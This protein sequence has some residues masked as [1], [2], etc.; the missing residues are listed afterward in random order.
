MIY[1]QWDVDA[2]YYNAQS[3][4]PYPVVCSFGQQVSGIGWNWVPT[5]SD[6]PPA[7]QTNGESLLT[8]VSYYQTIVTDDVIPVELLSFTFQVNDNDVTLNWVTATETNNFGFE[9]QRMTSG[10][11]STIGFING[12]G[13]S[14]ETHRYSYVDKDLQ[15]GV[16]TYRLKQIDLDG[17]EYYYDQLNVEVSNPV[18]F[19]LEQNY[20]N[21]FNP[22]TKIS[23]SLAVDSRVN[24]TVYNLLGETVATLVNSEVSAGNHDVNFQAEN[25]NSGI[26]F[27]RLD[28]DGKDGSQFSQVRKMML[29]K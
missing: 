14:T 24:L 29:T 18:Q 20:P 26:Y 13:T 15:P 1:T 27:Y 28:V 21:P 11:F 2:N 3:V 5:Y 16:Y 19:G 9:V 12:Y 25:L 17:S 23:Y 4:T 8:G 22:S 7:T 10:E 6:P